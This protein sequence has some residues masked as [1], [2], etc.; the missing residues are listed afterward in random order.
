MGLFKTNIEVANTELGNAVYVG[1]DV[2]TT[3]DYAI[4]NN[5]KGIIISHGK[6]Y[7]NSNVDFLK[8]YTFIENLIIQYYGSID[9]TGIHSLINLKRMALNIIANDNQVIDFSCFPFIETCMFDWRPKA[10]SIFNCKSLKYLR[11]NKLKKDDLTDFRELSNIEVLKIASS[12]IKSLKGIEQL[13]LHT[14]GLYYLNRLESIANIEGLVGTLKV[15]DIQTC[16]KINSIKEISTL[17]NL[18][19]LGINNCGDI[20]SIK[21]ICNLKRLKSFEFWES[22]NILDGD[23]SPCLN[24]KGVAFQ[25]RKHYNHTYE[26]IYKIIKK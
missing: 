18:E 21:P 13:N 10:K 2:E 12:S 26:D 25:N 23:I 20:D 15:L 19:K 4:K 17:E 24:L 9:L 16:K 11:I 8:K 1:S 7:R 22:T 5:I 3:M 6:G 14:L